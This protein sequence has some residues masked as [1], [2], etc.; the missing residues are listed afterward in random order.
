MQTTRDTTR[1]LD[2]PIHC[3]QPTDN[4]RQTRSM[5]EIPRRQSPRSI[6]VTSSSTRA[7]M[8][9]GCRACR[10][11]WATS[12]FSLPRA[13][14]IGRPA[15]CC[16][17]VLPVC[18]CVVSFSKARHAR[19]VADKSLAS[20]WHPRPTRPIPRD[21]LATFSRGC[22]EDATRKLP[23]WNFSLCMQSTT[24]DSTTCF[25]ETQLS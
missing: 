22:H 1:Y 12:P 6:L 8:L 18:P 2:T 5:A 10:T 7:M 20:S 3:Q 16:G 15:V 23:P 25:R 9:R 13:C 17:V 14:L 24:A 19:L 11:C 4:V 21:M